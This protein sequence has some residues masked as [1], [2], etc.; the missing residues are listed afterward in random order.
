MDTSGKSPESLKATRMSGSPKL[1]NFN[2]PIGLVGRMLRSGNRAA[3]SALFREALRLAAI[4][5]DM[6]LSLLERHSLKCPQTSD[7]PLLF[8][9]GAPRSGTTLIYQTLD[10]YLDVVS[11]SNLTALFPRAPLTAA[12]IQNSLPDFHRPDFRNFYGQTTQL[13]GPNDAFHLWN[14]WLGEDRY[15]PANTITTA[16]AEQMKRFF[17]TWMTIF[18][19]PFLNKNNRNSL[20]IELLARHLP[21]AR[22]IVV[23]RDPM[24]VAQSLII[25][26]QQVQGDKTR[27]WGLQSH[28]TERNNDPLA[29]V[30]DVCQQILTISRDMER[31]LSTVSEHQIIRTSYEG[32]CE[33][34]QHAI[35]RI[36]DSFRGLELNRKRSLEQLTPFDVSRKLKISREEQQRIRQ[37]FSVTSTNPA[38]QEPVEIVR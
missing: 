13:R 2:D 21:N 31:Q 36:A 4:P 5:A 26:R 24:F 30:N 25:A 12:R 7:L 22:F 8:I 34:P 20:A 11:P 27:G 33:R 16:A 23:E 3:Y 10:A 38:K 9:V 1:D 35:A 32:F 19:K 29:Y 14:R 6:C 37:C 18:G 15:Q 28:S 17:D